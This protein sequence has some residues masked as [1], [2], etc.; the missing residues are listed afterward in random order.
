MGSAG[1]DQVGEDPAEAVGDGDFVLA[2]PDK[3][4]SS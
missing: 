4:L 3:Y 1:P 2:E